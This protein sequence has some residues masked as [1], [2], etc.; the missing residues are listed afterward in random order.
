MGE[1]IV[2][3]VFIDGQKEGCGLDVVCRVPVNDY[4][5]HEV[6]AGGAKLLGVISPV[7]DP[8]PLEGADGLSQLAAA[9]P[10]IEARLTSEAK[11]WAFQPVQREQNRLHLAHLRAPK[12]FTK[13]QERL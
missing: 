8:T 9:L 10:I 11:H 4:R 13:G 6:E 2:G 7:A 5:D 12:P 1:H 3:D